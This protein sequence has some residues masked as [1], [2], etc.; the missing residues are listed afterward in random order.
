MGVEGVVGQGQVTRGDIGEDAG[1]DRGAE[2]VV[3][4]VRLAGGHDRVVDADETWAWSPQQAGGTPGQERSAR[5]GRSCRGG[6]LSAASSI[7]P[8]APPRR[9]R[10]IGGR[11]TPG[12]KISDAGPR[13]PRRFPAETGRPDSTARTR[14]LR[15]QRAAGGRRFRQWAQAAVARGE[16]EAQIGLPA[17]TKLHG[18][19]RPQRPQIGHRRTEA[20]VADVG[21][22]CPLARRGDRPH[23]PATPAHSGRAGRAGE[24]QSAAFAAPADDYPLP[25]AGRASLGQ[26]WA[27]Q[28]P[29]KPTVPEPDQV[30]TAAL[31]VAQAGTGRSDPRARSSPTRRATT[32]G[33]PARKAR[34][35]RLPTRLGQVPGH[36]Q[37][38]DGRIDR[39]RDAV[40]RQ[41]RA[42][43]R[44]PPPR[45]CP[46]ARRHTRIE[47]QRPS[48]G[49]S[50][51]SGQ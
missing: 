27:R 21:S 41:L 37:A 7:E 25:A 50:W 23:P 6:P 14:V 13:I 17:V 44:P 1:C 18:L 47:A 46:A 36:R 28:R 8:A 31:A 15:V 29:H 51:P 49:S 33:A 2:P 34:R 39:A 5:S 3:G 30:Q 19:W 38:G 24:A 48:R 9:S 40:I 10:R 12:G 43:Q 11:P 32:G 4:G 26:L 16:Q 22:R 20:A 45:S 35:A 42:R